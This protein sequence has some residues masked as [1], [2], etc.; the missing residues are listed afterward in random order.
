MKYFLFL[1]FII[2]FFVGIY[3]NQN[4]IYAQNEY[5]NYKTLIDFK[6]AEKKLLSL[7]LPLNLVR[8]IKDSPLKDG[9]PRRLYISDLFIIEIIG[10][11]QVKQADMIAFLTNRDNDNLNILSAALSLFKA[12]GKPKK[13]DTDIF[14]ENYNRL[15]RTQKNI[16]FRTTNCVIEMKFK[17]EIKTLLIIIL[18]K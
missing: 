1:L 16:T 18:A 17:K 14:L 15:I 6:T 10:Y 2:F 3:P 5:K 13:N 4:F 11:P 7:L 9:P 8:E 12:V